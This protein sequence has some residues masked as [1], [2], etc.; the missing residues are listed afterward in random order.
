MSRAAASAA[1]AIGGLLSTPAV[2]PTFAN[3]F[4]HEPLTSDLLAGSTLIVNGVAF[5]IRPGCL[6]P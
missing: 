6:R 1:I 5:A 4:V 2:S 3:I